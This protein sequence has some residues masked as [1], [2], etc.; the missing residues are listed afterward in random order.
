MKPELR[1]ALEAEL[2]RLNSRVQ[3]INVLLE[4]PEKDS[5]SRPTKTNIVPEMKNI[6]GRSLRW[7]NATP[8]QREAW[9]NAIK[10]GRKR[11][12]HKLK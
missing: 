2:D 5:I 11:R 12:K 9:A 10:K 1:R 7:R 6:D 4:R 8:K 3:A